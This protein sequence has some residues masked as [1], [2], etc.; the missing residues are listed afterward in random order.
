MSLADF[1]TNNLQ[2]ERAPTRLSDVVIPSRGLSYP[3][4]G[5]WREEVIYF[6][7]PNHFSDGQEHTRTALNNN[8]VPFPAGGGARC[9][10][11]NGP[12]LAE[13]AGKAV[14]STD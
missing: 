5:D 11:I 12:G 7:L 8:N 10:G 6:V 3:S 4:P 1:R 13:N 9:P 2:N 14:H